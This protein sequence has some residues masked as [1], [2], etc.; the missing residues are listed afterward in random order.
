TVGR[1]HDATHGAE[2]HLRREEGEQ[3]RPRGRSGDG[4]HRGRPRI[5]DPAQLPGHVP[6][7]LPRVVR[8][9]DRGGA[10]AMKVS[11]LLGLILIL[12]APLLSVVPRVHAQ[13]DECLVKFRGLPGA[14]N[15]GKVVCNEC[16]AC[17]RDGVRD[18]KCTFQFDICLNQGDA[19]C[20][21]TTLKKASV[22]GKGLIGGPLPLD[23]GCH[24]FTTT[25]S[26]KKNG[27]KK[28]T[29]RIKAQAISSAKPARHDV[30]SL[31]LVCNPQPASCAT[32]PTTTTLPPCGN[33]V[34]D[35][36]EQCDPAAS[37]S[38]CPGGQA[39]SSQ[40]Q[41]VQ[42]SCDPIVPG[43]SIANTYQLSGVVG[44]KLCTARATTNQFGRCEPDADCGGRTGPCLQTPW[45][46]ADGIAFPF[47]LGITTT[48]TVGGADP[49]PRCEHAACLGCGNPNA[50]CAGIPG[51]VGNP[52]CITST[53]CDHPSFIA[54]T[55]L[56]PGL[57]L[58]L[59]VHQHPR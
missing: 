54:P 7:V 49:P 37:P 30:D 23:S 21:A 18:N 10:R 5:P 16:D 58:C 15:G 55:F 43:E 27:T 6:H 1:R 13:A 56:L 44:P 2:E 8:A 45:V 52:Q 3:R 57:G 59:R 33:G 51:C 34:I 12:A 41:C 39:C 24:A 35:A 22:K 11:R 31:V 28:G 25:V 19:S 42:V 17:D 48:F 38:G 26:L 40:C 46:T 4:L 36:G 53:C 29:A 9:Q 32:T 20:T 14:E 50:A 47:P